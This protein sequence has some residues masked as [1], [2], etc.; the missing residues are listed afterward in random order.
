MNLNGSQQ[1]ATPQVTKCCSLNLKN[2]LTAHSAEICSEV[3]PN[4]SHTVDAVKH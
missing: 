3:N 4:T 1:A 2:S